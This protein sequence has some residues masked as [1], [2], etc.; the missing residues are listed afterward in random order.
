MQNIYYPSQL[1]RAFR[2]APW[3][4]QI[5]MLAGLSIALLVVLVI[6]GLYLAVA[7]RAGN[8]GRDLQRL[9][10]RK[11]ELMRQNDRLRAELAD[12]RELNRMALRALALG[13]VP[14]TPDQ[15][16]YVAVNNYPTQT[17]ALAETS[18]ATQVAVQP[19]TLEWLTSTLQ[20]LLGGG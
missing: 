12:L 5:Q 8:A 11:A 14:A 13:F 7:S 4:Q 19:S 18:V 10:I 17:L 3:R 15:V 9:E 1:L 16:R 6:G 20:A 2:Q